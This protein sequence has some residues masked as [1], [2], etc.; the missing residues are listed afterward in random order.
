MY[1]IGHQFHTTLW[2]G[3]DTFSTYMTSSFVC[4]NFSIFI[5]HYHMQLSHVPTT[6][7]HKIWSHFHLDRI[8]QY[9][10]VHAMSFQRNMVVC[11]CCM[12][13]K[14][15]ATLIM[16]KREGHI[17]YSVTNYRQSYITAHDLHHSLVCN[18]VYTCHALMI[19]PPP[20][21]VWE[22]FHMHTIFNS[23]WLL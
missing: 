11:C 19:H 9:N 10:L 1:N 6:K 17:M 4:V 21:P 15:V 14:H 7:C 12:C 2:Y 3:L 13:N 20:T 5:Q 8:W 18:R 16:I 22:V 23:I